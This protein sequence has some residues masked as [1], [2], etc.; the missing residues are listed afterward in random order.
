MMK[1]VL[2]KFDPALT[3]GLENYMDNWFRDLLHALQ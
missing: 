2:S 1:I 3:E